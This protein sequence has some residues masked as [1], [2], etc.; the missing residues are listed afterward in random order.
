[1]RKL[2]VADN[3]LASRNIFF[4][5]ISRYLQVDMRGRFGAGHIASADTQDSSPALPAASTTDVSPPGPPGSRPS[6]QPRS[7]IISPISRN[8]AFHPGACDTPALDTPH[9]IDD[10]DSSDD[11]IPSS[12]RLPAVTSDTTTSHVGLLNSLLCSK[13]ASPDDCT[14]V[15][16]TQPVSILTSEETDDYHPMNVCSSL[17]RDPIDL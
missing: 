15:H 14:L 6:A 12:L 9:P 4:S 10:S 11:I 5:H 8:H 1:M 17:G 2:I 3:I 7:V 16:D 13:I